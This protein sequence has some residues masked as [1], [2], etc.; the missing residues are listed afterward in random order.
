MY[1]L[2]YQC[3]TT[4]VCDEHNDSTNNKELVIRDRQEESNSKLESMLSE[5]FFFLTPAN[6]VS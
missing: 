5:M 2:I 1:T 4:L 6:V 3:L